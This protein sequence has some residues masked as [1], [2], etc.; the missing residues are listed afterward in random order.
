MTEYVVLREYQLRPDAD[1]DEPAFADHLLEPGETFVDG[2]IEPDIVASLVGRQIVV[3]FENLPAVIA[4]FEAEAQRF[5]DIISSGKYRSQKLTDEDVVQLE[6]SAN[7]YDERA[8]V[9]SAIAAELGIVPVA[10]EELKP[11]DPEDF[12]E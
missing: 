2:N 12:E 9:A 11:G 7:L 6:G 10:V 4:E 8:H 5:R 1:W 3:A